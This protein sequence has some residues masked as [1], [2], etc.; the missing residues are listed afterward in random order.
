MK[1]AV[2]DHTRC[3]CSGK[4]KLTQRQEVRNNDLLNGLLTCQSC[5]KEYPVLD[6]IPYFAS[7]SFDFHTQKNFGFSWNIFADIYETEKRDF[8][9]WLF[10]VEGK[11]F[12]G[13]IVLDAGCG[14]GLHSRMAAEFGAATVVG[15]DLSSAVLAAYQ[16]TRTQANVHILQANIYNPPLPREYF[17]YIYSIGVI[18]HLPDRRKAIEVLTS[19]LKPG[20]SLS[21]WVYGYEG[22]RM[23]RWTVEPIRRILS[24]CPPKFILAISLLPAVGFFSMAR[25]YHSLHKWSKKVVRHLPL[26]TYF[27]YMGA[28]PFKYQFNTVFDQLV[29]PRTH[30]FKREELVAIFEELPFR[31]VKITS[32]NKMSWR[33][34]AEDKE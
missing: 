24:K 14:N 1:L 12:R 5:L 11:W 21:L 7:S 3:P 33:V 30:Y 23:V 25:L 26:G 19:R 9:H 8:L 16:N 6:G 4:L 2:L 34:F 31:K 29:A 28:F 22:T 15:L 20:G 18:Q 27:A 32:R 17:D 13:K 10:P